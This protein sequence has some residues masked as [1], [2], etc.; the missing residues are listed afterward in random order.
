MAERAAVA[1]AQRIKTKYHRIR[2]VG[3]PKLFQEVLELL[4]NFPGLPLKASER[5]TGLEELY[6][7]ASVSAANS[8]KLRN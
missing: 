7:F 5:L 3:E 2:F 4:K 8:D 1:N 6:I